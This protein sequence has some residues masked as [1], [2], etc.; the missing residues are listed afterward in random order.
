MLMAFFFFFKTPIKKPGDGR[1]VTFFEPGSGDEN[2]TSKCD[3]TIVL[4][5]LEGSGVRG[6]DN[7]GGTK[8]GYGRE[9]LRAKRATVYSE[10]LVSPGTK[11]RAGSPL[12]NSS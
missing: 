8:V 1:K 3:V 10:H 12:R 4:I 11:S 7:L 2:G 5:D 9:T 6:G